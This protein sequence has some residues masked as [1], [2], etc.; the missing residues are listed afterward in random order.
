MPTDNAQKI[1]RLNAPG[2]NDL[3][4]AWRPEKKN[5]RSKETGA[6]GQESSDA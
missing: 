5:K 2:F 6:I 1:S 4:I 3:V